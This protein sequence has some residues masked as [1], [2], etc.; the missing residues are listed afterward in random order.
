[1]ANEKFQMT[2]GR[3]IENVLPRGTLDYLEVDPRI[4][5]ERPRSL[6]RSPLNWRHPPVW[7][8]DL[9]VTAAHIVHGSGLLNYFDPDPDSIAQ[10]HTP[11][12]FTLSAE[13]RASCIR[14]G[15]AWS[16][17][18][19]GPD[20]ILDLWTSI[21]NS[22]WNKPLRASTYGQGSQP[23]PPAWWKNVL[24]LLIIADEAC[25]G[26]GAPPAD[27]FPER[28]LVASFENLS[29]RP[30]SGGRKIRAQA[31][32]ARRQPTT[33]G[34]DTDPDVACVQPKGR[35]SAVGCNLRNL[36]KNASYIPPAGNLRCHWMQPIRSTTRESDEALDILIVPLPYQIE[37]EAF[38][39]SLTSGP[40]DDKRPNWGNFDLKQNWLSDRESVIKFTL[41]HVVKAKKVLRKNPLN[42]LI[43]PEYALDEELFNDICHEVKKIEPHLEFAVAGSSSNCDGE[44]ANFVLT[45]LWDVPASAK[46]KNGKSSRYLLT[47]RRK[48]HRWRLSQDQIET[49]DLQRSL[50]PPASWWET[51][52]IAQREIHLFH[53]RKTSVFTTMICEDLARSDPCHD[54]L[55]AIGPNLVFALLMDGPQLNSRW[56]GRY[57]ATL[58]DDPGTSVLSVTSMGLI[59]RSNATRLYP[60]SRTIAL[61]RDETGKSRELSLEK[62]AKTLLVSLAA[63]PAV[64]Q[65]LD[66]RTK[67]NS[68]SWQYD[69]HR[70]IF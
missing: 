10:S 53:F 42:G 44:S 23:A 70:S 68:W 61:W 51:H 12:A 40:D 21:S 57:A 49:Y 65:T 24:M 67:D 31:Y 37:E 18:P 19:E 11:L 9:F 22:A 30:F 56:P 15:R 54:I 27:E 64:D 34:I 17:D 35:I 55:R 7:P 48:H 47:S 63:K 52:C 26:L 46:L 45:A 32:R 4:S 59:E 50:P 8:T 1:M 43:F 20:L 58:A 69:T 3:A 25:V 16:E 60:E 41:E 13:E 62:G 14:A 36:T 6:S 39:T 38:V 66:G 28:W 29:T 33:Y 5:I 2:I